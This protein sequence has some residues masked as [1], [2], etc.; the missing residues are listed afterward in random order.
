MS[1]RGPL[2]DE[3][4]DDELPLTAEEEAVVAELAREVHSRGPLN[5]AHSSRPTICPA[6]HKLRVRATAAFLYVA[7]LPNCLIP[8]SL[9]HLA[10]GPRHH[11]NHAVAHS[12]L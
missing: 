10:G 2:G 5:P 12:H 11:R 6:P 8:N 1:A 4:D 3:A 7:P 9:Y